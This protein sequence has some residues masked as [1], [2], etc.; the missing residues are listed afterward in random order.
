LAAHAFRLSWNNDFAAARNYGFEQATIG[1][2][3]LILDADEIIAAKITITISKASPKVP[4]HQQMAFKY[5]NSKL[6]EQDVICYWLAGQIIKATE[7][8]AGRIWDG[9]RPEK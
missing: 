6:Y 4:A 5:R 8:Y 1:D 9:I 7:Q 2:W 3:V